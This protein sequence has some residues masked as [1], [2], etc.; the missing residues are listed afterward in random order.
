MDA[1]RPE[2]WNSGSLCATTVA[3]DGVRLNIVLSMAAESAHSD[4]NITLGPQEACISPCHQ[5][6]N[7]YRALGAFRLCL[8]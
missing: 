3:F 2:C 8:P 1:A 4:C 6:N 7:I 5:L